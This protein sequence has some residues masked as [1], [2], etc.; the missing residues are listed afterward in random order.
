[1]TTKRIN[2]SNWNS[3]K[4][5]VMPLIYLIHCSKCQ[6][7]TRIATSNLKI[8]SEIPYTFPKCGHK[9]K[10]SDNYYTINQEE[11]LQG[12]EEVEEEKL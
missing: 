11:Y 7:D 12:Y 10:G 4:N 3:F 8:V 9:G 5:Q 1:M 2:Y 6:V